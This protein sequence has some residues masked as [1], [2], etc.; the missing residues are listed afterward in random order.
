MIGRA[1]SDKE[2]GQHVKDIVRYQSPGDFDGQTLPGELVD[3]R[4]HAE[5]PAIVGPGLDEVIGPDMILPERPQSDAGSVIEPEPAALGLFGW[6]LQPLPSPDALN[7]LVVH[8]PALGSEQRRDPP[9]AVTAIEARQSDDCG[10]QRPLVGCR[11]DL[12][13]L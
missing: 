13:S 3:H 6:N 8:M 1:M 5:G 4:Q 2:V 9:I 11:H 10:R 7:P 12:V